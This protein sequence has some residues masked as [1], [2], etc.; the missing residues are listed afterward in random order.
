MLDINLRTIFR[1]RNIEK[2]RQWLV[3]QGITPQNADRLLS[4]EQKHIKFTDLERICLGLKCSPTDLFIW[5]PDSEADNIP[6]HPLQAIRP[7]NTV[8][9]VISKLQDSPL[10]ELRLVDDFIKKLR[11]GK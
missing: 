8:P 6:G 7:E 1:L 4:N 3:K 11:E 5:Q 2:P 10:N 9:D